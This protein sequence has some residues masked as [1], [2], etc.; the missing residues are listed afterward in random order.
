MHMQLEVSLPDI[1]LA[2]GSTLT[3]SAES[4]DDPT[5]A[6]DKQSFALGTFAAGDIKEQKLYVK[7]SE[8]PKQYWRAVITT[9]GTT[10]DLSAGNATFAI[11]F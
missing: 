1:T 8:K 5:F 2:A 3:V 6:T 11:V 7:P 4:C 10:G 9:T